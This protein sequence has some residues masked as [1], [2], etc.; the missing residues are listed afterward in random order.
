[1][2]GNCVEEKDVAAG[3]ADRDVVVVKAEKNINFYLNHWWSVRK[4][5]ENTLV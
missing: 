3:A 4:G 1:L 2:A 5:Q